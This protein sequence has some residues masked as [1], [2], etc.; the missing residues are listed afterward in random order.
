MANPNPRKRQ[1]GE[2][3]SVR[4]S[5][6]LTTDLEAQLETHLSGMTPYQRSREIAR[7][8]MCG[9]EVEAQPPGQPRKSDS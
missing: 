8:L 7:L 4:L 6:Y 2:G 3:R 5:A 9:L 1:P